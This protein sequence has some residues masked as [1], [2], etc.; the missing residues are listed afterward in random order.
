M[1][2]SMPGEMGPV[3]EVGLEGEMGLEGGQP[4]RRK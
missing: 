1:R 4:G 2:R 3:G